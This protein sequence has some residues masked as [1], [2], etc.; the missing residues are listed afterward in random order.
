[1]SIGDF[2]EFERAE[3]VHAFNARFG[4]T[5]RALWCLSVHARAGLL[6]G[7]S[8][9]ALEE[10]VWTVKSRWNV[11]G[12]RRE[13][14]TLMAGV[15][16]ESMTWTP[17]LFEPPS[18]YGPRAVAFAWER[19]D[20]LASSCKAPDVSRREYGLASKVLH[21]LM[22]WR[23][24]VYDGFVRTFLDVPRSWDPPQA[25]R[26]ITTDLFE[27]ARKAAGESG[28]MG[29]LPPRSP[30]RA[31][32]KV[33]W[34]KGAGPAGD[35][36]ITRDPWKDVHRLGLKCP[37]PRCG[38]YDDGWR[39]ASVRDPHAP[40]RK[41]EAAR[42]GTEVVDAKATLVRFKEAIERM[43][44]SLAAASKNDDRKVA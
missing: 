20:E 31:F 14:K 7:A 34:S 16:A 33:I 36:V 39:P 3:A 40:L 4:E 41:E 32:D 30:L 38:D 12:V 28:W 2:P 5:E 19:V 6:A 9:P 13:M 17:E 1:M 43:Q 37:C 18:D 35:A 42:A 22:P 8:S 27:A 24:P 26:K 21:W 10:L 25:Y 15:L 11:A 44:A 29:A 23:V